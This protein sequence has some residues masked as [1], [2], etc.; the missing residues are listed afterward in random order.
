M[1]ALGVLAFLMAEATTAPAEPGRVPI[2]L[3]ANEIRHLMNAL[4]PDQPRS[5]A[6]ILHWSIGR[7]THQGRAFHS[8]CERRLVT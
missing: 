4:I 1:A 7:R 5:L 2:G 8:H 3:T 6:Q